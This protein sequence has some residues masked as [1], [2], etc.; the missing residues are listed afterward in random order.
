MMPST[1]T[2]W[3]AENSLKPVIEHKNTTPSIESASSPTRQMGT[4]PPGAVFPAQF[5]QHCGIHA[6]EAEEPCL[7]CPVR[8]AQCRRGWC[9]VSTA[10]LRTGSGKGCWAKKM[11]RAAVCE[12]EGA[13][14]SSASST[15]GR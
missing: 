13:G 14:L 7:L 12:R 8:P 15:A 5:L 11:Y 6:P 9:D 3:F 10:G 2:P 4:Q 1:A